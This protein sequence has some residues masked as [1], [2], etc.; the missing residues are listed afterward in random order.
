M[1]TTAQRS[2]AGSYVRSVP[3]YT[4]CRLSA[5]LCNQWEPFCMMVV[6]YTIPEMIHPSHLL[7]TAIHHACTQQNQKGGPTAPGTALPIA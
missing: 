7:S 1:V 5:I 3:A 2:L 6:H 4:C